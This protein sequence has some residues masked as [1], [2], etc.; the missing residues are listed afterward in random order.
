MNWNEGTVSAPLS[1]RLVTGW[2]LCRSASM[3]RITLFSRELTPFRAS[4]ERRS[5][6]EL[7]QAGVYANTDTKTR[8][9]PWWRDG[10]TVIMFT[11]S[12]GKATGRDLWEFRY[13]R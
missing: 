5:S 3:R 11:R 12:Q 2:R 13:V 1:A 8:H 6:D 9:V 7:P 10:D 4:P